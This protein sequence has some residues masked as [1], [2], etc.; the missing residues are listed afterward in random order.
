MPRHKHRAF[1]TVP[2]VCIVVIV[3]IE[4]LPIFLPEVLLR[5]ARRHALFAITMLFR[6]TRRNSSVTR[7]RVIRV[8]ARGALRD[9]RTCRAN[10]NS[11][12]RKT[13]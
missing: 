3:P 8:L 12:H 13:R 11:L 4:V 6:L 1:V 5:L 10:Q 9:A 2:P 7:R